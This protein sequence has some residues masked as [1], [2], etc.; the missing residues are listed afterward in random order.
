MLLLL[1][2]AFISGVLTVFS[3]C[4]LPILPIVLTSGI[5]GN[6]K[7]IRGVIT[8]LVVTFTV[9]TL[10]L[11]S[12]VRFL[13]I[14]VDTVRLFAVGLLVLF[15]LS[16]IFPKIWQKLQILIEKFWPNFAPIGASKD[17]SGFGGGF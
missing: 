3:P 1:P 17:S 13:G 7:R 8:G 4:I 15:G 12:I 6:I 14:P 10:I 2:I 11:A 5:D 9:L 16:L